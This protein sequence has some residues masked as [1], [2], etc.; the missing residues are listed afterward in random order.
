MLVV[1]AICQQTRFDMCSNVSLRNSGTVE[2]MIIA[3][4]PLDR[5]ERAF[6]DDTNNAKMNFPTY[7][8]FS[9]SGSH[10]CGVY[11][12]IMCTTLVCLLF[13]PSLYSTFKFEELFITW[14]WVSFLLFLTYQ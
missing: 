6:R 1:C 10:M 14:I 13:V 4:V 2:R 7:C 3:F 12:S 9:H 11:Y 5:A 8:W